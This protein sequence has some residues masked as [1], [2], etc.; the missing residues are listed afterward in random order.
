[1]YI[2]IPY[3]PFYFQGIGHHLLKRK[4]IV[5]DVSPAILPTK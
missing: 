5:T 1:M 4:V 3:I 2:P